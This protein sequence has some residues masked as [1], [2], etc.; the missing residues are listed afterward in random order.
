MQRI[1]WEAR[2]AALRFRCRAAFPR[3]EPAYPWGEWGFS[4]DRH[5]CILCPH[6][7]R[8]RESW[9]ACQV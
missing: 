9:A 6:D 3:T 7:R 5:S 4:T 8:Q 2:P 1:T